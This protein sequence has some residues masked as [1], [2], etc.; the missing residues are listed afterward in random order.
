M[1]LWRVKRLEVGDWRL[2][3]RWSRCYSGE[4]RLYVCTVVLRTVSNKDLVSPVWSL[5]C[6]RLDSIGHYVLGTSV[7]ARDKLRAYLRLPLTAY[8]RPVTHAG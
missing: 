6:G 4:Y 8:Q 1:K 7:H 2:E 3:V 5:V